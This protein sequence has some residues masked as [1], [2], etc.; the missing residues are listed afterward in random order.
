MNKCSKTEY[1]VY[2]RSTNSAEPSRAKNN[3]E[4]C[5]LSHCYLPV[6]AVNALVQ[7]KKKIAL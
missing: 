7:G 3:P 1:S 2:G 5:L 4:F 6:A